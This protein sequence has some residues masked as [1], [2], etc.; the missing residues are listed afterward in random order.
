[1][2]AQIVTHLEP[3]PVQRAKRFLLFAGRLNP[4]G[5]WED[6][7]GSFDD[8][9]AALEAAADLVETNKAAWSHVVDVNTDSIIF[10]T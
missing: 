2:S 6:Y 3:H 9:V 4:C 5:G 7:R 8:I 10:D 1:M